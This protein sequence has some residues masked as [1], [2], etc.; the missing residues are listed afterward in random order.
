MTFHGIRFDV[1]QSVQNDWSFSMVLC[2]RLFIY[3][4]IGKHYVF[5]FYDS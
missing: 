5:I 1:K 4:K 3:Y 2:H